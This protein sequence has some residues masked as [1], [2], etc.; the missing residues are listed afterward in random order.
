MMVAKGLF[1]DPTLQRYMEPYIDDTDLK[2]TGGKY[3][4]IPI[5]DK[6]VSMAA[7][8]KGMKI[9]VGSGVDGATF[10]H[11]T[12]ALEFEALVKHAGMTR[13]AGHAERNDGERGGAGMAGPRRVAWRRASMRTWWPFRAIPLRISPSSSG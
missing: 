6:A 3:R 11:G 5:F 2:N 13:G 7:N 4:I 1:Y 12:Q 9:M 10:V 8:T